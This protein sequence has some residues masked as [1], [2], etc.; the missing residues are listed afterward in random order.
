M[1]QPWL[2]VII[3]C[4]N[5]ERWLAAALQSIVEQRDPG[6]EIAFVDASESDACLQI[7]N[8]F[9]DRLDIRIFHRPDLPYIAATNFGAEQAGADH[10][11][12]LHVDDLWL[13]DR[14]AHL[15]QWLAARPEAVMH[16]HSCY[17]IDEAGKRGGIWR[18]PLPDDAAVSTQTLYERLLIQNFISTPTITTRRDAYLKVGGLDSALWYTADWDFYLKIAA[19]GDIFYHS[20][21]LACYRVHKNSLSFLTTVKDRSFNFRAQHQMVVDRHISALPPD[22]R[23]QVFRVAAASMD[24][25]TALAAAATGRFSQ[26]AKAFFAILALG[27]RGIRQYLICSRIADRLIPR[28]RAFLAGRL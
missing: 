12:I 3:P 23:Q 7:A 5:G 13:P 2:S 20:R 6:I 25:N 27:P 17:I 4:R 14:C 9:S 22:R 28:A 19:I 16:L 21:P 1:Q 10:I 18:C 26:L 15:R 11:C 24:V 8:S